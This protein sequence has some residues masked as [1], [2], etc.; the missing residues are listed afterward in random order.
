MKAEALKATATVL[1][2]QWYCNTLISTKQKT[3]YNKLN[4]I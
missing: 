4:M 2:Q 3:K 1:W